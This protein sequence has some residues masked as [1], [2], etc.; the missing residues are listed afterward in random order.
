MIDT[1]H[2]PITL[3]E[4]FIALALLISMI[5][6]MA[7]ICGVIVNK[8]TKDMPSEEYCNNIMGDDYFGSFAEGQDHFCDY[9]YTERRWHFNRTRFIAALPNVTT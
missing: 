4:G 9:N 3:G 7:L 8:M 6:I 2:K 5:V 1:P